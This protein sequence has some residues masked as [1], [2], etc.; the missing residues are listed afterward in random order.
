MALRFRV[1]SIL[2]RKVGTGTERM[3][4]RNTSLNARETFERV[5]IRKGEIVLRGP[6]SL[7]RSKA[8]QPIDLIR[9]IVD[10]EPFTLNN[11]IVERVLCL[12]VEVIVGAGVGGARVTVPELGTVDATCV[13]GSMAFH[14]SVENRWIESGQ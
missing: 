9:E 7:V 1:K 12:M 6:A 8:I 4:S 11:A 2:L 14:F 5:E 13:D 10:A 3:A